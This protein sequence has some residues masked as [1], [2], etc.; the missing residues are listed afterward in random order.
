MIISAGRKHKGEPAELVVLSDPFY[1]KQLLDFRNPDGPM[2]LIRQDF[3]RLIAMF[4]NKKFL[5]ACRNCLQPAK[6]LA[7]YK[8]TLFHESWCSSCTPYWLKAYEGRLD[9]FCDY[10]SALEY[11][12]DYCFGDRFC[13]RMIIRNMA[14]LKGLPDKFGAGEALDFFRQDYCT[15]ARAVNF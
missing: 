9:I 14:K 11:V 13:Y 3:L 12:D 15:S 1:V 8:G 4:D 2:P 6:L 5:T 10:I 7:F